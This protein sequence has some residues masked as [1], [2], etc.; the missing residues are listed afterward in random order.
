MVGQ[1]K[2]RRVCVT[3]GGIVSSTLIGGRT[4]K[5]G[6]ETKILERG[7]ASWVKGWVLKKRG[8]NP[9]TNYDYKNRKP[10]SDPFINLLFF[11]LFVLNCA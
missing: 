7:G 11:N 4:E 10:L 3:V 8:W 1:I 5:R 9:L 6:G 2:A